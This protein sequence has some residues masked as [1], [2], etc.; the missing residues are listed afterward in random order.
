MIKLIAISIFRL[1]LINSL[2]PARLF[3]LSLVIRLT[4]LWE[5]GAYFSDFL[6]LLSF[7]VYIRGITAVIG[8]FIT[9]F[10][11]TSEGRFFDPCIF[12]IAYVVRRIF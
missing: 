8:Y 7:M 6:S 11:K 2:F 5:I 12:R 4:V 9:F 10:P 3:F 1:Y